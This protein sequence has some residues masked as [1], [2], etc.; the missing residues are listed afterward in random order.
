M[1]VYKTL[2][3]KALAS[4][5]NEGRYRIF[6]DLARD[7]GNFP[8]AQYFDPITE[9]SRKVT[10]WCSNDY[11]G[12]GQK[13]VVLD[14]MKQAIDDYG[15]GAGGTRNISGTTHA[16]VKLEKL[17]AHHHQKDAALIFTSGYISNEATLSTLPKIMPGCVIFS[18]QM[19]HASMIK[20][21]SASG[22]EKYIFNHNDVDH[23]EEL[24]DTYSAYN[25][26]KIIA[27][28]SVYSMDGD[29]A[30]I[31]KICDLADK[32]NAITYLTLWQTAQKGSPRRC[33][34]QV[35]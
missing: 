10:I 7:A 33:I 12:M 24:L 1:S 19:N 34:L 35:A 21:I 14:A 16:H 8:Y 32:Y 28:E 22:C 17:L 4:V 13:P 30:P 3:D 2:F 15:A 31:E 25:Q 18:D 26:P 23:L 27:F 29:I 5:H 20:G 11:L 6:A 9:A